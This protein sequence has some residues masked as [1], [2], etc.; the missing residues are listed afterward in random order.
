MG[1]ENEQKSR[2]K[3][4]ILPFPDNSNSMEIPFPIDAKNGKKIAFPYKPIN[5]QESVNQNK[6][7]WD[8]LPRVPDDS[9]HKKQD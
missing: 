3:R 9:N 4:Q 5:R 2:Q 7:V 8:P 6:G 1:V